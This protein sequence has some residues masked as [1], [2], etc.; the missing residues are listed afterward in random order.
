MQKTYIKIYIITYIKTYIYLYILTYINRNIKRYIIRHIKRYVK[1]TLKDTSSKDTLNHTVIHTFKHTSIHTSKPCKYI[2]VLCDLN[3]LANDS[4]ERESIHSPLVPVCNS[5]G[6]LQLGFFDKSHQ[7]SFDR[8]TLNALFIA[9]STKAVLDSARKVEVKYQSRLAHANDGPLPMCPGLLCF[10]SITASGQTA[11]W[12]LQRVI[13][14]KPFGSGT[15]GFETIPG[16][17]FNHFVHP[18]TSSCLPR[19]VVRG[20]TTTPVLP[21][22]LWT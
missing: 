14:Q 10:I 9:G 13:F 7:N 15:R 11:R 1:D 19:F 3:V 8:D 20:S 18:T 21:V 17:C 2:P 16:S 6:S 12:S 5:L 22:K 4:Q